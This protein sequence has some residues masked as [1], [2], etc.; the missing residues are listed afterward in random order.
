MK[1]GMNCWRALGDLLPS[2]LPGKAP[3]AQMQRGEKAFERTLEGGRRAL[4][5]NI[6]PSQWVDAE[7]PWRVTVLGVAEGEHWGEPAEA[8]GYVMCSLQLSL[9]T[10]SPTKPP[11]WKRKSQET[12]RSS[13]SLQRCC[14]WMW[15]CTSVASSPCGNFQETLKSLNS[16]WYLCKN[17][18]PTHHERCDS[19]ILN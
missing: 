1:E 4:K 2:Q 16:F 13:V 10:M 18:C 15:L 6:P 12:T 7:T 11:D 5:S 3:P 19:C 8:L 14:R 17:H 9:G